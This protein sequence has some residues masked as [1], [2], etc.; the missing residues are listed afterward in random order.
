MFSW[1]RRV[2]FMRSCW[3]TLAIYQRIVSSI[4]KKVEEYVFYQLLSKDSSGHIKDRFENPVK[5]FLTKIRNLSVES[6]KKIKSSLKCSSEQLE[7]GFDILIEKLPQ[8]SDNYSL[9]FWKWLKRFFYRKT[10]LET[11]L[12]TSRRQTWHSYQEQISKSQ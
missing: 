8:K 1:T 2:Q 7:G 4:P 5:S 3:N 11:F 12:W 9:K 6:P 10:F